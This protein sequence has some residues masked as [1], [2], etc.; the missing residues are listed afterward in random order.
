[1]MKAM[2]RFHASDTVRPERIV[3][4]INGSKLSPGMAQ[5]NSGNSKRFHVQIQI[6]PI[7]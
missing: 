2:Q 4:V 7:S 5:S 1:M 6:N 3:E